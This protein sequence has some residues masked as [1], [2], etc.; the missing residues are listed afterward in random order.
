MNAVGIVKAFFPKAFDKKAIEAYNETIHWG[1]ISERKI[2]EIGDKARLAWDQAISTDERSKAIMNEAEKIRNL[3]PDYSGLEWG[4]F[5]HQFSYEQIEAL[6]KSGHFDENRMS[7]L[8]YP[9]TADVIW[10][11]YIHKMRTN[12]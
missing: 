11:K 3:R 10:D 12:Q 5:M 1:E 2:R 7:P 9:Y 8:H 6:K 4:F